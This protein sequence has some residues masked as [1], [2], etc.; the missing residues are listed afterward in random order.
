V[1]RGPELALVGPAE[2]G[3]G[4]DA[5]CGVARAREKLVARA[6]RHADFLRDAGLAFGVQLAVEQ[7]VARLQQ[8]SVRK[9]RMPFMVS[10]LAL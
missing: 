3:F 9:A 7:S 1:P 8:W 6:A 10:K 5:A 2:D 4:Q